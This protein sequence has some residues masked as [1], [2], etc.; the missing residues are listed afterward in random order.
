MRERKKER[1][2]DYESVIERE[3]GRGRERDESNIQQSCEHRGLEMTT[4]RLLT[5]QEPSQRPGQ[6]AHWEQ[7]GGPGHAEQGGLR[8]K[9]SA[10][11]N[12]ETRPKHRGTLNSPLIQEMK[13]ASRDGRRNTQRGREDG[14]SPESTGAALEASGRVGFCSVTVG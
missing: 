1:E 11:A 14:S 10:M 13:S 7:G 12:H 4:G 3:R 8:G 9:A 5:A 2:R 6:R